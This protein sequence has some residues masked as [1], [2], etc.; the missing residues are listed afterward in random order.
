MSGVMPS[1]LSAELPTRRAFSSAASLLIVSVDRTPT[2]IG[3][4][5]RRPPVVAAAPGVKR[6]SA[7]GMS[8]S[9]MPGEPAW[10]RA[11]LPCRR[12]PSIGPPAS[13]EEHA[14]VAASLP[15]L[16]AGL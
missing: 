6:A 9:L 15:G 5:A 14:Q 2:L 1:S 3:E 10:G 12:S 4:P 8:P 13:L 16:R 7:S 11:G